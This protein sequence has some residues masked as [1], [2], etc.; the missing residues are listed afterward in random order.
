VVSLA[1]C[2]RANSMRLRQFLAVLS[3]VLLGPAVL[4]QSTTSTALS[5]TAG[6]NSVTTVKQGTAVTLT[7]TVSIPTTGGAATPPGQVQFCEVRQQPLKCTDIRLLATEQ[8]SSAGT[9]S[10]KYFPGPG[11]HTYQAVFLGTHTEAASSS[12][13]TVLVVIPY[14]PTTTALTATLGPGGYT[15]T[16][17]VTG[18]GGSVPPTGTVT[19]EDA[20][21]NN[22]V[23]GTA[24]LVAGSATAPAGLSFAT[25][26]VLTTADACLSAV[27]A[28]INGDGKPDLILGIFGVDAYGPRPPPANDPPYTGYTNTVEVFLGN[29]DG[30]FT[31]QPSIPLLNGVIAFAVGDFIRIGRRLCVHPAT[32]DQLVSG[33]AKPGPGAPRQWRWHV[34]GRAGDSESEPQPGLPGIP[35]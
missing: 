8:L 4:A 2:C 12:I 6:G 18:S 11:T 5:V 35:G 20:S 23:L 30:T 17:T 1:D 32:A 21:N 10:Y 29:G 22:Y 9:A 34:R 25:S 31:R 13:S 26:Q 27:V 33:P 7:A 14:L 3:V 15:L 24:Q 19:F 16:A 28:D